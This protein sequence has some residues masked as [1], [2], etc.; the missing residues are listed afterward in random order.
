LDWL[1]Q[2][3]ELSR[4]GGAHNVRPME[5]LRGFA[6]FLVFLVHYATLVRSWIAGESALLVLASALQTIGSTGVDL[7][8]VL[9][10]YLIYG[11]LISRPQQFVRF[12]SRRVERI[13][14]AFVAV[15]VPYVALSFAFPTENKIP[16]PVS[17]AIIYL[18]QNLLLLP[19]LF[20]IKPM[21][22]VAWS[23]SYEMFYYLAIPLV[24]T[25][26]RFR[27]RS[28][29][30]RVSFFSTVAAVTAIYCAAYGGHVRLIMFVSGILLCEAIN[31]RR[32][33]TPNSFVGLLALAFGLSATLLPMAGS[34]GSTLKVSILFVSFF[35]LCLACFRDPS[36]WLPRAFSWTPLRW[37]GNMSY[38]YYLLHGLALKAGFLALAV[39]LPVAEHSP[40][41]FWALL[42]A[43]F[44]LTLFPTAVLFLAVE[45]PYSLAPRRAASTAEK[46]PRECASNNTVKADAP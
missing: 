7:F 8:F 43:M 44:A 32:I 46:S 6:I 1:T 37:L 5:G 23:L 42:P 33:P 21:I 25:L 2:R 3:F 34:S 20:S 10:G 14:P 26:F 15:F 16:A 36:T 29:T 40:W 28:A 45:R 24:I 27:D 18:I 22:A 35:V 17:A 9:S 31:S 30:W 13:Y 38:S 19:G 39:V 11:S 41:L 4:G 12:M